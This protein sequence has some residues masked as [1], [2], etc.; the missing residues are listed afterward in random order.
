LTIA[1]PEILLSF[2]LSGLFCGFE[3]ELLFLFS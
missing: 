1:S 2:T 3:I